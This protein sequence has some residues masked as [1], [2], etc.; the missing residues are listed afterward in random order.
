MARDRRRKLNSLGALIRDFADDGLE[1]ARDEFREGIRDATQRGSGSGKARTDK[2]TDRRKSSGPSR[3]NGDS[4]R[5]ESVD[6]LR[7]VVR[8][9]SEK[10]DDLTE[11]QAKQQKDG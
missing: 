7:D 8:Q 5:D 10:I 9:L 11:A 4:G 1:L 3:R 6:E 2:E